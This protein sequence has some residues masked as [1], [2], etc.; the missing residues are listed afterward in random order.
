MS[1]IQEQPVSANP[2]LEPGDLDKSEP[3][4]TALDFNK[5]SAPSPLKNSVTA[6]DFE[7]S[8]VG[9]NEDPVENVLGNVGG[10]I[11]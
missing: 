8:S 10:A 4:S 7:P 1:D 5:P 9:S 6:A 3:A 2:M 11:K